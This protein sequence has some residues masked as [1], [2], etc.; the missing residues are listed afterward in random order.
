MKDYVFCIIEFCCWPLWSL[1][2]AF[3]SS[4]FIEHDESTQNMLTKETSCG[5]VCVCLQRCEVEDIVTIVQLFFIIDFDWHITWL[6]H[7]NVL[8][9]F[10]SCSLAAMSQFSGTR[11]Y[12]Q[13]MQYTY[14]SCVF[15]ICCYC[16]CWISLIRDSGKL[17]N[18]TN[19]DKMRGAR[20]ILMSNLYELSTGEL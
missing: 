8:F 5:N 15:I 4:I 12:A 3:V 20:N 14:M 1:C 17:L 13:Y 11:C 18:L 9:I 7:F 10:N 19:C 6:N 2:I 16:F